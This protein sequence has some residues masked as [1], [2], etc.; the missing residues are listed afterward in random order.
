MEAVHF[1]QLTIL[2]L[3][4]LPKYMIF[5]PQKREPA[6]KRNYE[7]KSSLRQPVWPFP[8]LWVAFC[9]KTR[10]LPP[11]TR[12]YLWTNISMF[13]SNGQRAL[14][15]GMGL[16]KAGSLSGVSQAKLNLGSYRLSKGTSSLY[17]GLRVVCKSPC[18]ARS[19]TPPPPEKRTF[20]LLSQ[21]DISCVSGTAEERCCRSWTKA[22]LCAPLAN[23]R[24]KFQLL[25]A[26]SAVKCGIRSCDQ[27]LVWWW[28]C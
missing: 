12:E 23:F 28:V 10:F 18:L 26:R 27:S 13:S 9:P 19:S 22:L 4:I 3:R 6:A 15:S 21:P 8:P 24:R 5:R 11:N 20:H 16:S 2:S 17:P 14:Q 1:L 25:D 7:F